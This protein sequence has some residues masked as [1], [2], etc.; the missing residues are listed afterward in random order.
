M[1]HPI[2]GAAPGPLPSRT[3]QDENSDSSI[4]R[5]RVSGGVG[6]LRRN[7]RAPLERVALHG[8]SKS[9]IVDNLL[10]LEIDVGFD[11][12]GERPL[13]SRELDADVVGGARR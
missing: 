4:R 5:H 2:D 1:L 13:L 6:Q 10:A 12:M 8:A 9:Q 11:A 7:P 3:P